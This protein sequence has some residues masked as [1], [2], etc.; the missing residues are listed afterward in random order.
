MPAPKNTFKQALTDRRPQ[1]GLWLGLA[2]SYSA[3]LLAQTGFDW[4]VIDGEHAPNDLRSMLAQL[5]AMTPGAAAP[6]IRLPA[7][8][9]WMVKQALDIGCQTILVPMVDTA[10]QAQRLARAMRY[11]PQGTRGVG[12]ALARASGFNAIPDYLATANDEVCLLVQVESRA[13]IAALDEIAAIDGVDGVFVGPADLAADMGHRGNPGHNEVRQVVE[14]A[15]SR[16]HAAGKPSGILTSDR[17]LAQHYLDLGST[18]V[19]V[20]SDIGLLRQAAQALR[21]SFT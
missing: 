2:D 21:A 16:I 5:Q 13:G 1:I 17:T 7:G 19:A 10:E 11:A 18:F 4:L 15:L 12:A 9:D 3:S 14:N 8:E 20:G 6:V